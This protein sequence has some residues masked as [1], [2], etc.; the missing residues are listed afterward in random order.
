MRLRCN[1][2]CDH[3]SGSSHVVGSN[4]VSF[5]CKANSNLTTR[6]SLIMS[7]HYNIYSYKRASLSLLL[8]PFPSLCLQSLNPE[9]RVICFWA[10]CDAKNG[11]SGFSPHLLVSCCVEA[12]SVLPLYRVCCGWAWS[13]QQS[14]LTEASN[15]ERI[16]PFLYAAGEHR[17]HRYP[18]SHRE[19]IGRCF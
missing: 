14:A 9:E 2:E 1:R 10:S 13:D 5:N 18:H 11:P 7:L 4:S 8:C 3:E 17:L 6:R 16:W 19:V 15:D 12:K